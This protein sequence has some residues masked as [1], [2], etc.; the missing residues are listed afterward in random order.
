MIVAVT[1][2]DTLIHVLR[3]T[4]LKLALN[5]GV[6][7][8]VLRLSSIKDAVKREPGAAF[9][10]LDLTA[11]AC[12]EDMLEAAVK[13]KTGN[14][15][16]Q[17]VVIEG[18]ERVRNQN[19]LLWY[20]GK[21]CDRAPLSRVESTDSSVWED[22]LL[23]HPFSVLMAQIREAFLCVTNAYEEPVPNLV[24]LTEMLMFASRWPRV[25]QHVKP[26]GTL[27]T[28]L[29]CFATTFVVAG[30][31]PPSE[32]ISAFRLVVYQYLRK[33]GWSVSRIALQLGC[34][35]SRQLRISF[36]QRFGHGLRE[37]NKMEPEQAMAIATN[38]VT[39]GHHK[40]LKTQIASI[41]R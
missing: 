33:N 22:L 39:P 15:S 1:L 35:N 27:K 18:S 4:S 23:N 10:V 24:G 40:P 30:Q 8:Q 37:L 3:A 34:G 6:P 9:L 5:N 2:S 25:K 31:A 28:A 36:N 20:L 16:G 32:I 38:L 7:L 19:T 21:L 14:A 13:W 41:L 11:C 26:K 12:E 29:N 17:L